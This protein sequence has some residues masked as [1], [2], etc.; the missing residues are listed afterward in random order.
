METVSST[1]RVT[2]GRLLVSMRLFENDHMALLFSYG[3]LREPTTQR[4]VFGRHLAGSPDELLGYERRLIT[5]DDPQFAAANGATQAI[6]RR[7]GRDDDRTA[8]TVLE[9]TDAELAIADAYEPAGYVRV[10]A[11]FASGRQGWV[12]AEAGA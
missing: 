9:I 4:A 12:Y 5:I 11:R 7:T 6:V 10:E 2:L 8:G 3:T 1:G